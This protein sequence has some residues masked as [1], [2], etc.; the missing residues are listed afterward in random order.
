MHGLSAADWLQAGATILAAV[1]AVSGAIWGANLG[2]RRALEANRQLR[3]EQWHE[4]RALS[5]T[6]LNAE[7]MQN[8]AMA[9]N[10]LLE[11]HEIW[12]PFSRS[13]FDRARPYLAL[14]VP[15]DVDESLKLAS[16]A[17][18]RYNTLV[19]YI[20]RGGTGS[21]LAEDVRE[22][23]TVGSKYQESAAE[24]LWK[25]MQKYADQLGGH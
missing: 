11:V 12:V 19:D 21:V 24:Q 2:A 4:D 6:A 10:E 1:G 5:L 3:T 13:A 16:A 14:G 20:N 25:F 18:E 23:A 8:V 22:A 17:I 7:L 15:N 9:C